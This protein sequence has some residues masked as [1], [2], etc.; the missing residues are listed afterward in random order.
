MSSKARSSFTLI[1]LVIIIIILVILLGIS[2]TRIIDLAQRAKNVSEEATV[3]AVRQSIQ[4]YYF[5]SIVKDRDP[6]Y[7][8]GLEP[9]LAGVFASQQNPFFINILES[10]GA[11]HRDWYKISDTAYKGPAGSIYTYNSTTGEFKE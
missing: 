6:L 4:M 11:V 7:P 3:N 5:E 10:T 1:E 9:A 2:I 8:A